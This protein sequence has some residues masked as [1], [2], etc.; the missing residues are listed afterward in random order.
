MDCTCTFFMQWWSPWISV[1]DKMLFLFRVQNV[2]FH[3]NDWIIDLWC[4]WCTFCIQYTFYMYSSFILLRKK[5]K[6][7]FCSFMVLHFS[8]CFV[9]FHLQIDSWW[10]FLFYSDAWFWITTWWQIPWYTQLINNCLNRHK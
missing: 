3:L 4:I 5:L 1:W 7:Y 10:E 8:V 2:K 9:N 6:R